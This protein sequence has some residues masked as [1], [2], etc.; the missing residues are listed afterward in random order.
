MKNSIV[1][2]D[3][4]HNIEDVCRDSASFNFT[5]TEFVSTIHDFKLKIQKIRENKDYIMTV[6]NDELAASY[7]NSLE[8]AMVEVSCY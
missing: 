7:L 1:I 3:E 8:D 2:L 4:A 5:E 6:M